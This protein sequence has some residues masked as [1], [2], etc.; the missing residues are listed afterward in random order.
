MAEYVRAVIYA[1][2]QQKAEMLKHLQLAV[3]DAKLR[4]R[5]AIDADFKDYHGDADF[6]QLIGNGGANK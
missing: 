4:E 2:L 1:R 5:A 3:A 6:L